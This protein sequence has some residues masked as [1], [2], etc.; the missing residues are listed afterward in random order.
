MKPARVRAGNGRSACVDLGRG[1]SAC[2][3]RSAG[4]RESGGS[5]IDVPRNLQRRIRACRR[6]YM[7]AA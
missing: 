2:T 6:S 7:K 1:A 5:A 4:R 3:C